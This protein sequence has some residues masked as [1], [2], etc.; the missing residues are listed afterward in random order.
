MDPSAPSW[1][2]E[3]LCDLAAHARKSGHREL[4]CDLEKV[5]MKHTGQARD[6]VLLGHLITATFGRDD[7]EHQPGRE[8]QLRA[9]SQPP[10]STPGLD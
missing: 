9:A 5:F 10:A 3:V 8:R 7:E 6:A 4:F 2:L 1:L